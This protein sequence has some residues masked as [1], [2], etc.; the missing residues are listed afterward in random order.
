VGLVSLVVMVSTLGAVASVMMTSPRIFFAMAD[1]RL[2]FHWLARVHPRFHTPSRSIVL[3]ALMATVYVLF[4]DFETLSDTFVLA[5]WPF[6][7]LA[8][9]SV[10]TLRHR[11]PDLPRPVRVLGYPVVPAVFVLA[12]ILMLAN[13]LRDDAGRMAMAFGLIA[14]GLPVYWVWWRRHRVP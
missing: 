9:L 10:F 7:A 3:T 6:Y 14:S 12:A 13:A 1:D 2:F 5:T 8:A 4:L 11:R